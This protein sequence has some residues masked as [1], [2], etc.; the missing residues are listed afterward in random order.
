MKGIFFVVKKLEEYV[1]GGDLREFSLRH[2]R[3]I[4]YGGVPHLMYQIR[5]INEF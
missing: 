3:K 5:E 1:G 4:V 2:L